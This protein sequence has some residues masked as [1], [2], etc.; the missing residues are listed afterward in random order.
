MFYSNNNTININKQ[1]LQKYNNI[2]LRSTNCGIPLMSSKKKLITYGLKE[3][4]CKNISKNNNI[5]DLPISFLIKNTTNKYR[6]T[7]RNSRNCELNK[8]DIH[9]TFM[10]ENENDVNLNTNK[11]L[12]KIKNRKLE[13]LISMIDNVNLISSIQKVFK[14][15]KNSGR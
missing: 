5:N 4:Y 1:P 14:I 6:T 15:W 7:D 12:I 9:K 11:Y 3:T 10:K 2:T 8:T 13:I